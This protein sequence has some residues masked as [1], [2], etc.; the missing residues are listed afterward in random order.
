MADKTPIDP[1]ETYRKCLKAVGDHMALAATAHYVL[2]RAQKEGTPEDKIQAKAEHDDIFE[3][4]PKA[5]A[6]LT[7]ARE[8]AIKSMEAE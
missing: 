2:Q 8:N 3:G 5:R 4:I 6:R 1:K 7:K